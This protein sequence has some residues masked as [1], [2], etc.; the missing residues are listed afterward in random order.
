MLYNAILHL[1]TRPIKIRFIRKIR[2]ESTFRRKG[3]LL[4]YNYQK[5]NF[6][7]INISLLSLICLLISTFTYGQISN[8]QY[9]TELKG[10]D[11]QW[12]QITLPT[13]IYGTIKTDYSDIRVFGITEQDTVEAPYLLYKDQTEAVDQ[14]RTFK[15]INEVQKGNAY[16]YTFESPVETSINKI[17]LDVKDSNFDWN[18]QLEGSQNQNEWFTILKDYRIVAI[19]NELTNY[20]FT[21]LQFPA[22][23][24]RYFRL[25]IPTEDPPKLVNA[26]LSFQEKAKPA[27]TNYPLQSFSVTEN[28]DKKQTIIEVQLQQPSPINVLKI[29]VADQ[30]DYYRPIRIQYLRDSVKTQKG[31]HYNYLSYSKQTLHSVDTADFL[32]PPKTVQH[33][34]IIIYNQD[35]EP[36]QIESVIAK[37]FPAYLVAR[38]NKEAK[39]YLAYGYAKARTPRYDI[40]RFKENIPT[41]ITTLQLG[42]TQ[43]V[44]QTAKQAPLFT[45]QV[46]LWALMAGLIVVLG[47]LSLK[48][49]REV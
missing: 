7:K 4:K 6:N 32:L 37:G 30:L 20:Q 29:K 44:K 18:V 33:L 34:R 15:Q 38:F 43:K 5:M 3:I 19:K 8:Y 42:I 36:L 13:E 9:L 2:V 48:M 28:K 47:G 11:Q 41:A 23:K 12:H 45:N 17:T 14:A 27:Y 22:A 40:G 16:Y 46:W 21:K 39:Y 24:Y 26:K 10:I 1:S 49:M 31:W 35:N 25:R